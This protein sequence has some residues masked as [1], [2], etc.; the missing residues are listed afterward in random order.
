MW[1][2]HSEAWWIKVLD[3]DL[4]PPEKALWEQHLSECSACQV[5]WA[6]LA[7]L[8]M[9]LRVAP[10]PAPPAD[11]AAKTTARAVLMC[12]QRRLWM[13]LGISF[14]TV[15]LGAGV[16]VALGTAYW[17]FNRLLAAMVFSKDMLLQVL[18]RTLVGLMLAGRSFSPLLLALAAGLLFLFMPHGVLATVAV[19]MV[20]RQ[21]GVVEA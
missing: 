5:E 14:L 2:M 1:D 7:Q 18:M 10:A 15:L 19:V 3:G 9:V 11:L 17:D 12:R 16:V 6:A 20:R 21:R 4:T 8:E 13:L